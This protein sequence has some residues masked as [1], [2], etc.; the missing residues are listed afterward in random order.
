[1][2]GQREKEY[3]QLAGREKIKMKTKMSWGGDVTSQ[4]VISH[5]LW[6]GLN[7][8]DLWCWPV[9]LFVHSNLT[10]PSFALNMTVS[11]FF[12]SELLL[13]WDYVRKL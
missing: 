4:T 9:I 5:K 3:D 8:T 1:M 7:M 6:G 13:A 2:S 11:Y 12:L 10:F